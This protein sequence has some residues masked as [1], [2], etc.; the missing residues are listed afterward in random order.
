MNAT[1]ISTISFSDPG[2]RFKHRGA[3]YYTPWQLLVCDEDCTPGEYQGGADKIEQNLPVDYFRYDFDTWIVHCTAYTS[4]TLRPNL[5][6]H[7]LA[8]PLK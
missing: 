7:P 4:T 2:F 3:R 1:A 5:A 6:S 8:N